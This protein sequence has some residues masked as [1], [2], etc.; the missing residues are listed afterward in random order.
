MVFKGHLS[1][2]SGRK[3]TGPNKDPET[4]CNIETF[5]VTKS[6]KG[7]GALNW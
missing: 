3:V 2:Q 7:R 6:E 4:T 1:P 5:Y